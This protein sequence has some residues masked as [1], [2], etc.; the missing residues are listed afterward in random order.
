MKI[1]IEALE[2]GVTSVYKSGKL[3]RNTYIE[4]YCNWNIR[5]RSGHHR[6]IVTYI[7]MNM[8][9]DVYEYGRGGKYVYMFRYLYS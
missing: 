7:H 8:V 9:I 4:T 5:I 3:S 6:I 1:E 2:H